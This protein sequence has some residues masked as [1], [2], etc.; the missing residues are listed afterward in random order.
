MPSS[1]IFSSVFRRSMPCLMV[2][3]LVSVPPSQRL[4]TKNCPA[5]AASSRMTSWACF[6]VPT[7]STEP[8]RAVTSATKRKAARASA[9]VFCRSMM[10]MPLRAPKMYGF[11]FGF[12][13]LVW[14]PK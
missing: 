2:L 3:K 6:L 12:Q 5:R 9:T 14:W 7:K 8:P 4:V 13:R 10:W 11:I 1:A